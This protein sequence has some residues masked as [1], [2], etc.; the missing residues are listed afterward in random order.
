MKNVIALFVFSASLLSV[1]A[2][3]KKPAPT[4]ATAPATYTVSLA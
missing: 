1:Q 3:T 4:P 2:Q